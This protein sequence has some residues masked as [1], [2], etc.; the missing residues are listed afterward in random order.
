L[1][2]CGQNS[3]SLPIPASGQCSKHSSTSRLGSSSSSR[4]SSSR[5]RLSAPPSGCPPS[6]VA[7][8]RSRSS[9]RSQPGGSLNNKNNDSR[10]HQR[11]VLPSMQAAQTAKEEEAA[12][13][14][15]K[16]PKTGYFAMGDTKA[17]VRGPLLCRVGYVIAGLNAPHSLFTAPGLPL[18]PHLC[19]AGERP[20]TAWSAGTCALRSLWSAA[21]AS[22][23]AG[24]GVGLAGTLGGGSMEWCG[25]GRTADGAGSGGRPSAPHP[26]SRAR[27]WSG[28]RPLG[29]GNA[30]WR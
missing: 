13:L 17:E 11:P 19:T 20:A 27:S 3:M 14:R 10:Q 6:W 15:A 9:Q 18:T 1:Q 28:A 12:V 22:L 21:A 2:N 24:W 30:R 29:Q 25:R 23:S 4:S 7:H 5:H 8:A 16:L 26:K